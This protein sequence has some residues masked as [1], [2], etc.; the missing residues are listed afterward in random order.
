MNS[1]SAPPKLTIPFAN[2]GSKNTIPVASQIGI[3]AG[4]ASFTDGFPPLTMQTIASGGVP[5]SGKDMNGILYDATAPIVWSAAGAGYVFDSAFAT[6]V[7]GYP[8][9]AVVMRTDGTGYWLNT[10]DANSHDPEGSTP[11]GWVP[12][13]ANGIASIAMSAANVTL[14]PAQ[15]GKPII[16]LSGVLTAN[17]NLIFPNIVGQWLIVNNCTGA[18]TVT[19]TTSA[20]IGVATATGSVQTV[21]GDG[22]NIGSTELNPAWSLFGFRINLSSNGYINF[23]SWLGGIIMQWGIATQV[24]SASNVVSTAVNF[25]TAFS[26]NVFFVGITPPYQDFGST[27]SQISTMCNLSGLTGFTAYFDHINVNLTNGFN[28]PW[29]AIGY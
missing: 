12:A 6:A 5:P 4:A 19:C 29:F 17:L 28:F 2:S 7:G 21:Y 25:N 8:M 20:G 15:Y 24:G 1:S 16:S 22:N 3:T 9:G 23:P 14:T 13:Y 18:Y 26:A 27:S 11:T 10:A